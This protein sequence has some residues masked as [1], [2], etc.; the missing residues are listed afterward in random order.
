MERN[1]LRDA[2]GIPARGEE[3]FAIDSSLQRVVKSPSFKVKET[4]PGVN[5]EAV[6]KAGVFLDKGQKRPGM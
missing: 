3:H 5:E 4:Q 1:V 2:I 6:I